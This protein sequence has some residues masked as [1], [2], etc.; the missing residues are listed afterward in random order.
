VYRPAYAAT[1][2][3][4]CKQSILLMKNQYFIKAFFSFIGP[5]FVP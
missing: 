4:S 2:V 1:F 5:I 3:L